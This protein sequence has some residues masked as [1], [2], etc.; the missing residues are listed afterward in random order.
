MNDAW[1]ISVGMIAL[2]SAD[3]NKNNVHKNNCLRT[4]NAVIIR[5]LL[6]KTFTGQYLR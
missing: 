1:M 6:E 3:L 2:L 5:C 4:N